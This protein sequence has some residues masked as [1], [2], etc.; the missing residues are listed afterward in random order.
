MT[1]NLKYM[2]PPEENNILG[3]RTTYGGG[4]YW[5]NPGPDNKNFWQL[6]WLGQ[7]DITKRPEDA[8]VIERG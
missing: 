3:P 7:R 1:D 4:G 5:I 6:G 8:P 2:F